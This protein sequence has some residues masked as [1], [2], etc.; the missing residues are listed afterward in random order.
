MFERIGGWLS[1][2][3]YGLQAV[4]LGGGLVAF[5]AGGDAAGRWW[6]RWTLPPMIAVGMAVVYGM[7][8]VGAAMAMWKVFRDG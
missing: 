1:L 8:A 5:A 6:L 3:F 2:A 7:T 4:A